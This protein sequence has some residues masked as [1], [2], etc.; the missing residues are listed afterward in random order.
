MFL[1]EIVQEDLREDRCYLHD[2]QM[3]CLMLKLIAWRRTVWFD[4]VNDYFPLGQ[5]NS[6]CQ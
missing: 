5:Q 6:K 2:D 3:L 4:Q 1:L